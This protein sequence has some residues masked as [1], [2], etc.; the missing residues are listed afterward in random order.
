[1]NVANNEIFATKVCIIT[2]THAFIGE[3]GC[4]CTLTF[5][6]SFWE[7]T[8]MGNRSQH[9]RLTPNMRYFPDLNP[10]EFIEAT[11][12]IAYSAWF[13]TK[14]FCYGNG[15]GPILGYI[16]PDGALDACVGVLKSWIVS[17][18]YCK[19]PSCSMCFRFISRGFSS[20]I[21]NLCIISIK[22][23]LRHLLIL[24]Q[25]SEFWSR[26]RF[27]LNLSAFVRPYL[28]DMF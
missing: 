8:F 28:L 6:R 18:F 17:A 11:A 25:L 24:I 4:A 7:T 22:H 20:E 14:E 27:K 1:M 2:A 23:C 3:V 10:D 26:M 19:I 5:D 21:L 16:N 9:T 12:R 15:N 13:F